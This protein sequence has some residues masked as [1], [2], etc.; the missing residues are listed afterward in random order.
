MQSFALEWQLFED[1]VR[2]AEEL[3]VK[4]TDHTDALNWPSAQ[5]L[6]DE[7]EE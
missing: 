7:I 6:R 2:S 5:H 3:M 4:S 1:A